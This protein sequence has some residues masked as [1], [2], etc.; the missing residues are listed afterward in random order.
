TAKP[1]IGSG[2][3]RALGIAGLTRSASLPDVP[4]I[5]ESGVPGFD[6]SSWQG[7]FVSAGTP[8]EVIA[9]LQREAA[10]ALRMADVRARM[11]VPANEIVGSTPDAFA[12][13]Y[14]SDMALFAKVVKDAGIPLQD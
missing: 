12:V 14:R 4:T 3:L 6:S 2:K 11:E 13:K 5:A 1:N 10:K 7:W 8:P 9:L